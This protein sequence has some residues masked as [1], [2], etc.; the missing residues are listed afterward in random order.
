MGSKARNKFKK[1]RKGK[2]F[3]GSPAWE[4]S[5]DSTSES[6]TLSSSRSAATQCDKQQ[7]QDPSAASQASQ[8]NEEEPLAGTSRNK[9]ELRG[10][11]DSQDDCFDGE[12]SDEDIESCVDTG[13]VLDSYF[14]NKKCLKCELYLNKCDENVE[15][16]EEWR[17]EHMAK[18]ECDA[19]FT[20]SSPAME[21]E[22]AQVLWSRSIEKHKMRYVSASNFQGIC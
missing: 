3:S 18:G 14:L 15:E 20:G 8:L 11:R 21:A 13:E 19:N 6:A 7:E 9:M 2:R 16:F 12:T 4:K 10:F 1:R 22:G 5:S 17:A